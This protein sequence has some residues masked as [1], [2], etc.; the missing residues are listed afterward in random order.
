MQ[1]KWLFLGFAIPSA[2]A[3]QPSGLQHYL[4]QAGYKD[5]PD[6][7]ELVGYSARNWTSFSNLDIFLACRQKPKL[8][9]VSLYGNTE[10]VRSCSSVSNEIKTEREALHVQLNVNST[11]NGTLPDDSVMFAFA[12]RCSS[13]S[14]LATYQKPQIGRSGSVTSKK[15]TRGQVL[16]A[17]RAIQSQ[18]L[19][20]DGACQ[21]NETIIFAHYGRVAVG[22]YSGSRIQDRGGAAIL[23]EKFVQE[24]RFGG[25]G[26]QLALQL[27]QVQNRTSEFTFGII[28]DA[29]SGTVGLANVRKA[30][31]SWGNATCVRGLE[32]VMVTD[33]VKLHF[34]TSERF[35]SLPSSLSNATVLAP[36]ANLTSK[37]QPLP[38]QIDN[39]LTLSKRANCR[40]T[41]V[42][43]GDG[44][45]AVAE[46]CRIS[47][48]QLQSY[49]G[50]SSFCNSL[51]PGQVVCCSSGSLPDTG[52]QPN[53][54]G[55]CADAQVVSGDSC[56]SLATKCGISPAK[57]TEYNSDKSLCSAVTTWAG[58]HDILL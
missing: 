8:F 24:L 1:T 17:V 41:E 52:P 31:E 9:E 11:T 27:C 12:T 38:Q 13:A 22:L 45:W 57:F 42:V 15:A 3:Q 25:M 43:A 48:T 23:V 53:P 33:P 19:H 58:S 39:S 30:A 56:G 4:D 32:D 21:Q 5:C 54:D 55:T 28:A 50:G 14:T 49:N 18:L 20:R 26:N 7:C 46:R 29:T 2:I 47:Q 6:S 10:V 16:G 36:S 40:T 51:Y 35:A 44:C 37:F 34:L